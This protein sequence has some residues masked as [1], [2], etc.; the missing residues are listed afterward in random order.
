[1]ANFIPGV[2]RVKGLIS[3]LHGL[4]IGYWASRPSIRYHK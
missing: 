4:S 3:F 1:V 2:M